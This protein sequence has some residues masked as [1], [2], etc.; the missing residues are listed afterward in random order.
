[1]IYGARLDK[2]THR[3]QLETQ[4]RM[5]RDGKPAFEGK[6]HSFDP[7]QQNDLT[8]L[9]VGGSLLL[10]DDLQPGE[11]VLQLIV[12]DK[13]AK[14]TEQLATTWIDFEIVR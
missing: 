9:V 6:V 14:A 13:L 7:G 8:R 1:M 5:F 11:Y 12:T 10:G 4:V 3:P 2:I